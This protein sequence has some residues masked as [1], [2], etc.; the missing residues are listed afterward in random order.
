MFVR[1]KDGAF[2]NEKGLSLASGEFKPSMGGELFDRLDEAPMPSFLL[3]AKAPVSQ[4]Y[5]QAPGSQGTKK[6]DRLGV[7]RD[8]NEFRN[9]SA[10][11]R[12][13]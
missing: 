12:N 5:D 3:D 7:L 4:A 13:D 6:A 2:R 11:R 9:R 10:C 1:F 8:M